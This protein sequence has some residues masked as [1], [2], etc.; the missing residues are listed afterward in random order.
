ML[1]NLLFTLTQAR[2]TPSCFCGFPAFIFSIICTREGFP[3]GFEQ[4]F[5]AERF[6][7]KV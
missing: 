1:H 5:I 4:A 6:L 2:M 7:E 3:Y